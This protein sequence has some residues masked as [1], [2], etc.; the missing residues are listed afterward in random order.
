MRVDTVV[1][2]R[3]KFV[4]EVRDLFCRAEAYMLPFKDINKKVIAI[5]R[6]LYDSNLPKYAVAYVRGVVDESFSRHRGLLVFTYEWEGKR[7]SI[8]SEEYKAI[9]PQDIY[10]KASETGRFAYR[11]DL[12]KLY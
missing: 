5:Y 4:S 6:R 2:K 10:E 1:R 8:E 12:T 7:L 9:R 3:D 11:K